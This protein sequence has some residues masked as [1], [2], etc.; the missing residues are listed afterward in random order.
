MIVEWFFSLSYQ[1][2]AWIASLVVVPEGADLTAIQGWGTLVYAVAG[3]GAWINVPA[4]IGLCTVALTW[5]TASLL[6][7]FIRALASHI[8][9]VGGRG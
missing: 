2:N 6:L 8:P 4:M 1:F 5:W 7:K 9:F 3:A